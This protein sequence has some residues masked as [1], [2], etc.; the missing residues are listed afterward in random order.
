MVRYSTAQHKV[1]AMHMLKSWQ[2]MLHMLLVFPVWVPPCIALWNLART[3]G[4]LVR[5]HKQ[6]L[7]P[8]SLV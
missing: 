2:F 7:M 3:L 5:A 4:A 1:P 6:S 8:E